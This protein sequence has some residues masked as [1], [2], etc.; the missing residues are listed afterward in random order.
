MQPS[1]RSTLALAVL[2]ALAGAAAAPVR[3]VAACY[4]SPY[5]A[6]PSH[7]ADKSVLIDST[8]FPSDEGGSPMAFVDP[9]DGSS[10]RFIPLKGGKILVWKGGSSCLSTPFLDLSSKVHDADEQGLLAMAADPDFASN[11]YVYVLYDDVACASSTPNC[12]LKVE[13]YARSSGN[14][15]VGDAASALTIL[16]IPH[17]EALN[18]NGG[19]LAFGPDGDL[20]VSTGDGGS[21]CDTPVR[22]AQDPFSIRGKL[23]RIDVHGDDFPLDDAKNYAIPAGNPYALG[24]GGAP[25]VWT[26]G[27]RNPFRFSFDRATGDLFIGDVGQDNFEEINYLPVDAEQ[28]ANFGWVCRE[29]CAPSTKSPSSCTVGALE[30]PANY[31]ATTCNHP[32]PTS[33]LRDPVLCFKNNDAPSWT[34][35]MGGY[36]YRGS[37]LPATYQGRYFFGDAANGQVWWTPAN[38]VTTASCWDG[39]DQGLYA[40]AED[41]SGELYLVLGGQHRIECIHGGISG[42]CWWA[43]LGLVFKD[44]FESNGT[45]RWVLGTEAPLPGP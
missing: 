11:G 14:P 37:E 3:A 39:G 25:E 18:H 41:S 8:A 19:W 26:L 20:Y 5:P 22:D 33:G 17:G 13:R 34:E 6:C 44:G 42:G 2:C 45:S 43:T 40:F 1:S 7:D 27:L 31:D 23:L 21:G 9:A 12:F 29:G 16:Q 24:I 38:D 32:D 10:R 15:D 30:C 35:I 4:H 36:R 28:P